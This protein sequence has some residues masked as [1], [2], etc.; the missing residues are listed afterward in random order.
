MDHHLQTMT[1]VLNS[2]EKKR[3]RFN[4]SDFRTDRILEETKKNRGR[5]SHTWITSAYNEATIDEME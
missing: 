1:T 4:Y 2:S 3:A 5:A